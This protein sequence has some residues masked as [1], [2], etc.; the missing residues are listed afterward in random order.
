LPLFNCIFKVGIVYFN[1][2]EPY[3][4]PFLFY[5]TIMRSQGI[6]PEKYLGQVFLKNKRIIQKM[7]EALEVKEKDLIL[8]I[9]AGKGILTESLLLKEA[10]VIAVEKDPQLVNFLKNRFDNNSKLQIIQGDIRD[11]LNSNFQFLIS[12]QIPNSK[13]QI[14]NSDYKVIGNI[15]YYLTSYLFRLL[16]DLKKKPKLVVLMVQKEVG[17]R[18]MG[19]PPKMNLLAV[20]VQTFFKPELI[21]NVSKNNFWPKP[22]VDSVVIK[23]TPLTPPFKT[24]KEKFLKLIKAGFSQPR[25]LLIN[26]LKN[27]LKISKNKLEGIFKKL[28]ISLNSRAQ[29]LSLNQWFSL[30]KFL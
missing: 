20:L 22:K 7:V 8:E 6:K 3:K 25:K 30:L 18:I 21:L 27:K 24:K 19:K 2:K 9:G 28:N 10:K 5:Q 11:L 1:K 26:N 29:D 16:I 17:Q 13:F 12:K 23:L 14:P 4:T 15:P